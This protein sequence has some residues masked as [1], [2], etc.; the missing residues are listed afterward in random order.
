MD[1]PDEAQMR[2]MVKNLAGEAI[3]G[4]EDHMANPL[5][6]VVAV[7]RHD[8]DWR[9]GQF[10]TRYRFLWFKAREVSL[11]PLIIV[12]CGELELQLGRT[13]R[14]LMQTEGPKRVGATRN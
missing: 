8:R 3:R 2:R 7:E 10:Q 12:E 6:K 11:T 9:D 13:C 1:R 4:L 5:S 14:R